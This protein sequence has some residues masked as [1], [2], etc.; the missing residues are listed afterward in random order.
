MDRL[1][2]ERRSWNMSRIKGRDTRPELIVRSVLH[3]LGFRFRLHG[4]GLPGRPD[5]VLARHRTVVFVHGCFWHRHRRC[6][7][8]YEPKTNV[9]FWSEK[10][11]Q[12]VARDSSNNRELRHRGWHV[13][14][15]WECQAADRAALAE[16]LAAA[17][18]RPSST[19][20]KAAKKV[21]RT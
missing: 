16:C 1:T 19:P 8:A 15:V 12:N 7:F 18:E 10:F 17:L 13:V 20:T 14:V 11:R 21:R 4:K 6:R 5:V 3:R 2:Q 9:T